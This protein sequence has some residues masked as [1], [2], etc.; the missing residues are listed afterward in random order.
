MNSCLTGASGYIGSMLARRLQQSCTGLRLVSRRVL[1]TQCGVQNFQADLADEASSLHGIFEDIDVMLHCAGEIRQPSLM[2][3][4][5]VGGMQRLLDEA[6]AHFLRTG[7]ALHWVQL[8][9]VGAYGPGLD[10]A[11]MPRQITEDS[12]CAPVGTYEISKTLADQLLID[13]AATQPLLSYTILRPSIVIGSD[14]PNQ[15]VRSLIRFISKGWFFYIGSTPSVA[16]YIHVDDVVEALLV[17]ATKAQ[18]RGQIFNLSNDCLLADIVAAVARHH[19]RQPPALRVPQWPLRLAVRLFGSWFKLPL[20]LERIDAMVR[21]TRY[22]NQ[23]I[24]HRLGFSPRHAIPA[25][26]VSLFDD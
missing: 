7:R 24:L 22:P 5:H 18:A 3:A 6:Q 4:L 11:E 23:K 8:S 9:S 17:C 16:T 20:S 13:F 25:T 14:M 19:G 2:Q 26:M 10:V 21:R 12:P 1:P 15:S